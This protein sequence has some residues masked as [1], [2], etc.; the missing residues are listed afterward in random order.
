M[1]LVACRSMT[2][3]QPENF[4][5]APRYVFKKSFVPQ[6]RPTGGSGEGPI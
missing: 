3:G 1:Q 6:K 2:L 4:S 5:A